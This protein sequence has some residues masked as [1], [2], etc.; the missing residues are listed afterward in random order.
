VVPA[1]GGIGNYGLG[2]ARKRELLRREGAAGLR[3]DE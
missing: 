1:S 2:K 3:L